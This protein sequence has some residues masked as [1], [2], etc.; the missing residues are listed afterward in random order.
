MAS[1]TAMSVKRKIPIISIENKRLHMMCQI[2]ILLDTKN[3]RSNIFTIAQEWKELESYSFQ[4][5]VICMFI[6]RVFIYK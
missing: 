6:K 4:Q 1:R 3:T 5:Y 2:N